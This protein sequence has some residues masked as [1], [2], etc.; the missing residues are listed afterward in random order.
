MREPARNLTC[1]PSCSDELEVVDAV[2]PGRL[3]TDRDL[4]RLLRERVGRAPAVVLERRSGRRGT[5]RAATSGSPARPGRSRGPPAGRRRCRRSGRRRRATTARPSPP[6]PA[7]RAPGTAAGRGARSIGRA[8]RACR[9]AAADGR[10]ARPRAWSGRGRAARRTP[11]S[12]RGRSA[13]RLSASCPRTPRGSAASRRCGRR[14]KRSFVC[15]R[16]SR[17]SRRRALTSSE[18]PLAATASCP[19]RPRYSTRIQ[20]S[21]R[22]AVAAAA[23]RSRARPRRRTAPYARASDSCSGATTQITWPVPT[24][25]PGRDG[26]LR[27]TPSRSACDLVLHLHRLDDADHLARRRPRRPRRPRRRAPCPASG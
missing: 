14:T 22:L 1:A 4:G 19:Q 21:T 27:T 24:G 18:R 2:Q 13:H 20:W 17:C 16:A 25:S 11:R 10:A 3:R 6:R 5:R 9:R 26:Q 15:G 7:P 8:C 23:R 12:R